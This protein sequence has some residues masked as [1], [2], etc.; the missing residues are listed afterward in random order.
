[1]KHIAGQTYIQTNSMILVIKIILLHNCKHFLV[2]NSKVYFQGSSVL[3]PMEKTECNHYP[4]KTNDY[5][6]SSLYTDLS[7]PDNPPLLSNCPEDWQSYFNS[8][9]KMHSDSP[10]NYADA[11]ADVRHTILEQ[12][13]CLQIMTGMSKHS[14]KFSSTSVKLSLDGLDWKE[15]SKCFLFHF[16]SFLC[17]V[18]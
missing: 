16:Y 18:F 7:L 10:L 12:R 8:C 15:S 9:F 5:I 11:K 6:V 4:L 14:L 2:L 17:E 1:M 13:I 3:W